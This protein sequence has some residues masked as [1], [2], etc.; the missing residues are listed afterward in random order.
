M[1]KRKNELQKQAEKVVKKF[2]PITVIVVVLCLVVGLVAGW[3]GYKAIT[4]NDTFVINGEKEVTLTVGETYGELG[5]KAI[6]FGK[7]ISSQIT[8]SG[9]VNTAV[10]GEYVLTYTVNNFKY[11]NVKKI[12]VVRVVNGN[13]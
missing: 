4:K 9:E 7:D 8:V 12:R 11:N 5:A 13:E 3:F 1:A 2:N 10:E 6:A